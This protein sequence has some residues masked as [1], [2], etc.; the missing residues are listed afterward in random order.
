[1]LKAL[2]DAYI[3]KTR[4]LALQRDFYSVELAFCYIYDDLEN[5]ELRELF[6][7][8][9]GIDDIL[10][11]ADSAYTPVPANE[12]I[13]LDFIAHLQRNNALPADF[14]QLAVCLKTPPY[15]LAIVN[16]LDAETIIYVQQQWR[17]KETITEAEELSMARQL[18]STTIEVTD[19]LD[20]L[21][22]CCH[23]STSRTMAQQLS[24]EAIL[25]IINEK[26]I[27]TFSRSLLEIIWLRLN[28]LDAPIADY[29]DL[30]KIITDEQQ[31]DLYMA[32]LEMQDDYTLEEL[33][34][35]ASAQPATIENWKLYYIDIELIKRTQE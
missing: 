1:M 29:L 24:Y 31:K 28:Q 34:T 25:D 7:P 11:V 6:M 19:I 10:Y 35:T 23:E 2:H 5:P 15:R 26:E 22:N 18:L 12:D 4:I 33:Y 8:S 21:Q 14:A 27:Y 20:F 9:L 32:I 3:E 17:E 16:H 30:A 13:E